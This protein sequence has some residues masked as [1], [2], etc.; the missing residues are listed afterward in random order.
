LAG[1]TVRWI[2]DFV[3]LIGVMPS[4]SLETSHG[5]SWIVGIVYWLA[6]IFHVMEKVD[7]KV[8]RSIWRY[9]A[10][11]FIAL[12]F[13]GDDFLQTY[14][15]VL[16]SW[17]NVEGFTA[18]LQTCHKIQMK[19]M[20]EFTSCLTYLHVRNN[21]VISRIYTGPSYLKRHFIRADNFNLQLYEPKIAPIVSWRPVPQYFWRAGVPRDRAAP[22]YLNL[23]RLIGLAYDTLGIDPVSYNFVKTIYNWTYEISA[24]LVGSA[25]LAAN[26]PEWLEA[27]VKYLRKINFRLAHNNF[28]SRFE[29]L[30]LNILDREYHMP[31]NVGTWQEHM[32]DFDWW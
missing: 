1:K 5:D 3:L 26:M 17:I 24:K 9:L 22:I 16:R 13:Y 19:N 6:Y 14:P 18:Y 12:F 4:G 21:E 23:A 27:D 30:R 25:F 29:L 7:V 15:K 2:K 28:P 11:R 10:A 31:K 8:R 20:Q 32:E